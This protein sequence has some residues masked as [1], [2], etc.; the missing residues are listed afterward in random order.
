MKTYSTEGLV[1][2]VDW[3]NEQDPT[4]VIDGQTTLNDYLPPTPAIT[5]ADVREPTDQELAVF[6][7][8]ES[9]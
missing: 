5:P 9:W 4:P 2:S 3:N 8:V 7:S 6:L 1:S